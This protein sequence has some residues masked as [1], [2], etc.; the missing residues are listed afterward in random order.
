MEPDQTVQQGAMHPDK[1]VLSLF[2]NQ[3]IRC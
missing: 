3:N 2:L 1:S